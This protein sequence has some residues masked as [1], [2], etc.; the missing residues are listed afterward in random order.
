[1]TKAKKGSGEEQIVFDFLSTQ[2]RPFSVQNIV[3]A[4]QK[5]GVKKT[6]V[7]RS[8]ASLVE[9]KTVTKKEYGK[10][11]IF[12][13]AQQHIALP[14]PDEVARLE[15][16]L[17]AHAK[18]LEDTTTRVSAMKERLANLGGQLTTDDAKEKV[19]AL[20]KQLESKSKKREALGD[21]SALVTADEKH[22]L[23]LSY[24]T[25][26]SLWKKYRRIVKDITDM[27]GEATGQKA[28]MLH[29][30]MDLETDEEAGVSPND[31]PDIENPA[32]RRKESQ[33]RPGKKRR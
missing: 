23:E 27:V 33:T 22:K 30:E 25:M 8:L 20:E 19:S 26:K 15:T 4:L 32:K 17:V 14:D 2:N 24:Y 12:I 9:K 7:E 11:K 1:M 10:A 31:F 21:G 13:L 3:D 28:K 18:E 5:E 6:A 16:E 29:E